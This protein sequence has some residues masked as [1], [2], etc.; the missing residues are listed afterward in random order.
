MKKNIWFD[1]II[2]IAIVIF[3][4]LVS[5]SIFTRIDLSQGKIYSLSKSSKQAVKNLEDRLVIKAYF[6]R[7]MP[8]HV[9]LRRIYFP[10]TR[11]I[12]VENYASNLS[13]LLMRKT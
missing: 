12:H 2:L 3:V 9:V 5:L 11:H 7:N 6:S 1:I 8:M 10:N 13:I 4:N